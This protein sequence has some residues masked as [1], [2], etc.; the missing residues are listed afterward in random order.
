M[1]V[2]MDSFDY[3]AYYNSDQTKN[4]KI[5]KLYINYN[6]LV[7]SNYSEV[8]TRTVPMKQVIL[9]VKLA[10]YTTRTLLNLCPR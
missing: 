10:H 6:F 9:S 1:K 3:I 2:W 7:V 4:A 5:T 8:Y